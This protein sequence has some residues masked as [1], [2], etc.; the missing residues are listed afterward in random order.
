MAGADLASG[1]RACRLIPRACSKWR[2]LARWGSCLP[3]RR[4]A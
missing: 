4:R 1:S 3:S 2:G